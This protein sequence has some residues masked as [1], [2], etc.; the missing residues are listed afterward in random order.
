MSDQTVPRRRSRRS[1]APPGDAAAGWRQHL[2]EV[3]FEA[4][5]SAGK[6]FDVGLLL[7]ILVSVTAVMLES[8]ESIRSSHGVALMRLEWAL[9]GLFSLEYLL[10]MVSVRRPE[11]YAMSFFGVVDL[12]A[13][14][15]AFI[16]LLVPGAHSLTVVRALRLLR[17]FR[18]FKLAHFLEEADRLRAALWLSR[19]KVAVFLFTVVVMVTILGSL[20]YVIEGEEA[21]FA[22]IPESVYWAVVTMTTVGYGD[23]TPVTPLGKSLALVLMLLGYA[24]IIVPTGILS[25]ELTSRRQGV[26]TQVCRDCGLADHATDA[27]FCR[28]CGAAL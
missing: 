2:H 10:R 26:S 25:A 12:L 8:V 5:T 6:A 28:E 20:M 16:G 11:A 9:T 21:G 23:I 18:I 4:E 27:R 14:L 17:V 15:P 7:A 22:S 19:R 1:E 3:I 13:I 24:T